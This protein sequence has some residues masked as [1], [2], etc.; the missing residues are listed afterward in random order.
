MS[1]S[2]TV[3]EYFGNTASFM[4]NKTCG[5]HGSLH[6]IVIVTVRLHKVAGEVQLHKASRVHLYIYLWKSW[7]S[8]NRVKSYQIKR[9]RSWCFF[10][11]YSTINDCYYERCYAYD[12]TSSK[13]VIRLLSAYLSLSNRK[14]W[15]HSKDSLIIHCIDKCFADI[16][17]IWI[18]I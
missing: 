10:S 16:N 4:V 9:K 8:K 6:L 13:L 14:F 1:Q 17:L 3:K 12:T 18:S 7:R 11:Y 15:S 5:T 2:Q